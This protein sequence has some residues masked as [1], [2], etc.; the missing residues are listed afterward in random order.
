MK[1]P[2]RKLHFVFTVALTLAGGFSNTQSQSAANVSSPAQS[3]PPKLNLVRDKEVLS[4]TYSLQSTQG[5][6]FILQ[7][8]NTSALFNSANILFTTPITPSRQGTLFLTNWADYPTRFFRLVENPSLRI[9]D[10]EHLSEGDDSFVSAP[11]RIY[12]SGIPTPL[13]A[14]QKFSTR[15]ALF[16]SDGTVLRFDGTVAL[17]LYDENHQP[18]QVSYTIVPA[19]VQFASGLCSAEIQINAAAN[20]SNL[21]LGLGRPSARP[22][23]SISRGAALQSLSFQ[24]ATSIS[25]ED[26]YRQA[27]TQRLLPI[28]SAVFS[29]V[30]QIQSTLRQSLL[31][32]RQM[33]GAKSATWSYPLLQVTRTSGT[34]GEPRQKSVNGQSNPVGRIHTGVDLFASADTSVLAAKDGMIS[35]ADRID[36]DG[37]VG[38]WRIVVDHND[39][40]WSRYLHVKNPG[41]LF[42][43]VKAGEP[44]TQVN[45]KGNHLHFEI[46]INPGNAFQPGEIKPGGPI[47]PIDYNFALKTGGARTLFA[48]DQNPP[49]LVFTGLTPKHPGRN[50]L[51][52]TP[53]EA[54]ALLD[55]PSSLTDL[56]VLVRAFDAE[57]GNVNAPHKV[58]FTAD[59]GA[60]VLV[61]DNDPNA[62]KYV[63]AVSP[64]QDG[65]LT[66]SDDMGIAQY[67][68]HNTAIGDNYRYWFRWNTT[69]YGNNPKG[70]RGF[71]I[72]AVDASGNPAVPVNYSFGP[73]ITAAQAST[74]GDQSYSVKVK[75]HLGDPIKNSAIGQ[76]HQQPDRYRLTLRGGAAWTQNNSPVFDTPVFTSD[77]QEQSFEF[78]PQASTGTSATASTVIVRAESFL[79]PN[80]AHEI[81]VQ[82]QPTKEPVPI[83]AMVRIPA[84]TFVMGS[85][86]T[87]KERDSNETQ[88]TVTLTRDFYMSKYEVTQKE[89]LAVMGSN[90]SYFTTKDW[91]GN[92]I[93]PDLN[94]PVE[95]VS[96]KDAM[97]YC[98]KVTASEQAAGRLPA[99]WVYRLPTEAEWEYAC[100][101]GTSTAF[102]YGPAL[103]GGMAN[104]YSY[105]EY[106]ASVG[107]I[108]LSDAPTYLG[109]T[110][111]V[112]SY[113]PNA[114]GLYDMHGN[115]WEWCLDRY[116]Y[117][118]YPSGSV[119]DP[120]G[121]STGSFR[122]I[123]GGS[124]FHYARYCRSAYR[125]HNSPDGGYRNLGFRPVLAPGQ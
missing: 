83:P 53:D 35:A 111:T 62:T 41:D 29:A 89:Y 65:Y 104:F 76:S 22:A 12:S 40:T 52:W 15:F 55:S 123:R 95:Q 68:N 10:I 32:L 113:A 121:P 102:H 67:G 26:F 63:P 97:N 18:A 61:F 33:Y 45:S 100:R 14:G 86:A 58:V 91:N 56:Y 64:R 124:W 23:N 4:L 11:F 107:S 108:S 69:L 81:P 50:S 84:G 87:E 80:I 90:P 54:R 24:A 99:G 43:P 39:G 51:K 122:V 66:P 105:W 2:S 120:R 3:G 5:V 59:D 48:L 109:R 47:N 16:S 85:P 119:T 79:V 73:D 37:P 46:L 60:H 9:A 13:V 93:N 98:A 96:W 36:A 7:S 28:P 27:Q 6:A 38:G 92:P 74:S 78:K 116:W 17:V 106:D 34:F 94:R 103:R 1:S 82:V 118:S 21:Q 112:G 19:T 57:S 8:F 70:P 110:T 31:D 75:A 20:L 44:F 117:G 115:V 42:V 101:A 71:K 114:F 49:Q 77:G 72:E 125:R 30:S 25:A 88:H